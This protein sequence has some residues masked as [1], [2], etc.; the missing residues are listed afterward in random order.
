MFEL[1]STCLVG[2]W[3][4][5]GRHRLT[6]DGER[7]QMSGRLS[8]CGRAWTGERLLDAWQSGGQLSYRP[9]LKSD[10][11]AVTSDVAFS[12]SRALGVGAEAALAGLGLALRDEFDASLLT[13]GRNFIPKIRPVGLRVAHLLSCPVAR[14]YRC[15]STRAPSERVCALGTE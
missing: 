12:R 14:L 2:L 3:F 11:H 4:C 8:R 13:A 10:Y 15:T 9:V 5:G 1:S 7:R 6:W